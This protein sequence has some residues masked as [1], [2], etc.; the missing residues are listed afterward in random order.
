[1]PKV[2][3]KLILLI[4]IGLFFSCEEKITSTCDTEKKQSNNM[5]AQLSAI[6]NTVFNSR[7]VSC[8]GG[9]APQAG[10]DLSAGNAYGELIGKNLV[11]PSNSANSPLM[12][13]LSSNDS[14]IVM[15]PA[16]KLSQ[17]LID[18]IAAWIDYGALNN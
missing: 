3:L 17:T 13:R 8:H 12:D 5:P 10:L 4:S 1:M 7:C 2:F 18:S 14:N 9:G 6:Q 15:P 11:L 16:G